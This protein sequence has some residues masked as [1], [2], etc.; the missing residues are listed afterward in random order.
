[1][2]QRRF[3][4][5]VDENMADAEKQKLI[6][7]AITK[8]RN[9]A[10][11]GTHYTSR[12]SSFFNA[13]QY[14]LFVYEIYRDVRLV[15]APP[16]AIGKFGGD[17]DNWMWPRHTGDFSLFRIYADKNNMPADYSPDNVPYKPKKF[18]SV[19][20]AG[21][22]E[23]DFTMVFGYPGRTTEYLPSYAIEMRLDQSNPHMINLRDK[24]NKYNEGRY[25]HFI[26]Y[27][28]AICIKSRGYCKRMEK[29]NWSEH[30]IKKI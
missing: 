17:T 28:P 10:V 6:R 3:F 2:L 11:K 16:S 23:G 26:C 24:K 30:G 27:S 15:G 29:I 20:T 9:E 4:R 22:K 12:V 25:E 8:I 13:N 7:A 5:D 21:V 1:M 14:Y 18:F 19:S